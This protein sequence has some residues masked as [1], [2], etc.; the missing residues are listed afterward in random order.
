MFTIT[1][2]FKFEMAHVLDG[3]YTEACQ[4]IHGHSYKMEVEVM[5]KNLNEDGM[6]IDFKLLKEIVKEEVIDV[7]D[8]Q[9][10]ISNKRKESGGIPYPNYITVDYNPTAENMCKDFFEKIDSKLIKGIGNRIKLESVSLWE[11]ETGKAKYNRS[12]S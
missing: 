11:T 12:V 9:F 3:S 5:C 4:L 6:V 8:H 1:K 2:V 7:Y 10:V